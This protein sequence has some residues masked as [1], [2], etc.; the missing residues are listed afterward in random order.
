MFQA[1]PLLLAL[2]GAAATDSGD[3]PLVLFSPNGGTAAAITKE[4]N[5]AETEILVAAY[6]L[7]SKQITVALLHAARRGVSVRILLDRRVPKARYSTFPLLRPGGISTRLHHTS[8]QMHWKLILI[9][10]KRIIV[11]SYNFTNNAE[12]RNAEITLIM[13]DPRTAATIRA[14]FTALFNRGIEPKTR[15]N[16]P[17]CTSCQQ[18]F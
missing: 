4:I 2:W 8:A 7:T 10:R 18:R 6:S 15:L 3:A 1:L 12:K 9:D 11:G 13:T 14:Q 17:P 16:S 5:A